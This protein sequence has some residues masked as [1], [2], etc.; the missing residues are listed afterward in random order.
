MFSAGI[1]I[2]CENWHLNRLFTLIKV[3]SAKNGPQKKMS[4]A[5]AMRQQRDLNAQR[6]AATG[7]SG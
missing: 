7:S 5:E 3:F 4:K 6:R 1:P 2:E